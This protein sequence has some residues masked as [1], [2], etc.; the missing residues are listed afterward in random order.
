VVLQKGVQ[1]TS[2]K[3]KLGCWENQLQIPPHPTT[4]KE[5]A[6]KDTGG[7]VGYWQEGREAGGQKKQKSMLTEETKKIKL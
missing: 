5:K 6:G 1:E 3:K 7:Y 4:V 2:K